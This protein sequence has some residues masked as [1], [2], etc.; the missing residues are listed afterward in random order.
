MKYLL[1]AGRYGVLSMLFMLL[2]MPLARAQNHCDVIDHDVNVA[3]WELPAPNGNTSEKAELQ[4]ELVQITNAVLDA[5]NNRRQPVSDAIS[6]EIKSMLARDFNGDYCVRKGRAG[7]GRPFNYGQ[8]NLLLIPRLDMPDTFEIRGLHLISNEGNTN[9]WPQA[10]LTFRIVGSDVTLT[11]VRMETKS[12]REA[13]S[14]DRIPAND[15][16]AMAAFRLVESLEDAYNEDGADIDAAMNR[17]LDDDKVGVVEI[18]VSQIGRADK[19]KS[20]ARYVRDLRRNINVYGE[21]GITYELVDVYQLNNTDVYR[22]TLVQHWMYENRNSYVD[23]DFLAID[24]VFD[25]NEPA[26]SRRQAGRGAFNVYSRPS[27]VQITKFNGADWSD[28]SPPR[29]TPFEQI[30]NA[31]LQ[32][33]GLTLDNVWYASVD[34]SRTPDDVLNWRNLTVEMEHLDGSIVLNVLPEPR[35]ATFLVNGENE[36]DVVNGRVIPIKWTDLGGVPSPDGEITSD[37][38]TIRIDVLHPD[39]SPQTFF[40]ETLT[41]TSP[42]PL[43]VNVPFP[44]GT[45]AIE[46]VPTASTVFVNGQEMGTTRLEKEMNVTPANSPLAVQVKNDS[47]LPGTLESECKLHIPSEVRNVHIEAQ[48]TSDEVFYLMPFLVKN[49]TSAGR[50][51]AFPIERNGNLVTV[52]YMI[53]DVKDRNRKFFV[54]FDMDQMPGG[55]KI[56]DLEE[57]VQCG[58]NETSQAQCLGNKMRPGEYVFTWDMSDW[59]DRMD[60][61]NMP[62]LTLRK[63][64]ACW[65]CVL[66]PAAAGV[67]AAYIW[68]RT[69]KGG[70]D[71]AFIPPPRP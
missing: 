40:A 30:M 5:I 29:A 20:A 64:T 42:D 24:V 67:A 50:I 1:H 31:P 33:H 59:S 58:G 7:R 28:A 15:S 49:E 11:D 12:Q 37:E 65:P 41:L 62:V 22:V 10:I 3:M 14:M 70:D 60:Q 45:L 35:G 52:R 46:S 55:K 44:T 17:I 54:D 36:Q 39:L 63:K 19:E 26:I 18:I 16:R 4:Q 27:N 32:Y 43:T 66:L 61:E 48:K 57:E 47:C 6:T 51:T 13:R 56:A 25:G 9:D 69:G 8:Y 68:P 2:S 34:T 38:R 21:T 71:G 23:S 53:E